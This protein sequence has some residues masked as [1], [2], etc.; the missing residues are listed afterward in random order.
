MSEEGHRFFSP[1]EAYIA[2]HVKE[3]IGYV[4]KDY[5]NEIAKERAG[6][7]DAGIVD[8]RRFAVPDGKSVASL[9]APLPP[10]I[11]LPVL[12]NPREDTDGWCSFTAPPNP[13]IEAN[14]VPLPA[15]ALCISRSRS[16]FIK[17]NVSKLCSLS[18]NIDVVIA[19]HS[20]QVQRRFG[21]LDHGSGHPKACLTPTCLGRTTKALA[22]W[23]TRRSRRPRSISGKRWRATSTSLVAPHGQKGWQRG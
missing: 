23:C 14:E 13:N 7:I 18:A 17:C 1:V 8:C 22:H 2:R 6:E 21:L 16:T 12:G 3:R 5:H 19:S 11:P 15:T 4:A 9:P 20:R 10:S